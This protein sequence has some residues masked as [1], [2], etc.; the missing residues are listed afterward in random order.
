M[1]NRSPSRPLYAWLRGYYVQ[2]RA[3][4]HA[5][6]LAVLQQHR[7]A[8]SPHPPSGDYPLGGGARRVG[9]AGERAAGDGMGTGLGHD[10]LASNLHARVRHRRLRLSRMH[11][12]HRSPQVKQRS[13]HQITSNAPPLTDTCG[14]VS[15]MLAP[16]PLSISMPVVVTTI[17]WPPD[18]SSVMP[19]TPGVSSSRM[20]LPPSVLSRNFTYGGAS[21][22]GGTS[23]AEPNQQPDQIGYSGSPCSN[24]IQTPAS[25]FGS[26][27]KPMPLPPNGAQGIAQPLSLSPNTSGTVALMRP[28]WSGSSMSVTMPRYLP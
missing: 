15:L 16:C 6:G 10:R 17:F 3:G 19:P 13:G 23:A 20:L 28:I 25:F 8:P 4:W 7:H 9:R 18:V 12:Q 5:D 2:P 11:A 21:S 22:T 27:K 26:A 14:P 24:S 1:G